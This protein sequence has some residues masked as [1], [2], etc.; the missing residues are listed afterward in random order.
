MVGLS[1]HLPVSWSQRRRHARSSAPGPAIAHHERSQE[2]PR[3]APSRWSR[4][5]GLGRSVAGQVFLLQAA[6]VVALVIAVVVALVLQAR[7]DSTQD[8]RA[9]TLAVA[10]TFANAP[11]T[12]RALTSR[13]PTAILQPRAEALRRQTGV[14][15]VVVFDRNGIRVTHPDP[16]LIGKRVFGPY[17]QQT[18]QGLTVTRTFTTSR[19]PAVD[20]GVPVF[21]A[22][23]KIVG[24]VSVAI[25]VQHVNAVVNR[26]VP[27]VLGAAAVA[28]ALG[29]ASSALVSRRLRR[30]THGLGP[31]EVTRMY[32][33]HDAVLH[34]VREGV[35][36]T[37][38]D[39]RL[40]LANDEARRLLDLPPD[41]ERRPI[42]ALGLDP[43]MVALLT[44]DRP[45]TDQV[46]LAGERLLVVNVRPTAPYGGQAGCA[47]TL[48]DAT[49]LRALAG[50]AERA[51]QRLRLLYEAGMRV[52]TTLDV[53]HTAEEVA[54]VAISL[55]AD[56]ATVEL[57]EP[58][59][60]GAE[61][62]ETAGLL[63]AACRGVGQGPP[64]PAAGECVVWDAATPMAMALAGGHAVLER[65][66]AVSPSW[67]ARVPELAR[68]VPDL[69]LRSLISVPLKARGMVLGLVTFWRSQH[70]DPFEEEDLPVAEELAARAAVCIDNARRYTREHTVAVAMQ[71]SLLPRV[72]PRQNALEVAHRYLPAQAG[73]GGDWFDV[74]PL[75]GA[76]V[77]LVVGDVVGHGLHAAVTMGRLRTAVLNFSALDLP[78]DELLASL[79][80]LVT[81]I[82]QEG[83]E[84]EQDVTG[85]TC[86]Y[87]IYDPVA[88]QV[89]LARAG[90]PGP[91]LVHRDGTVALPDVP[92]S[93][94]LGLGGGLPVESVDL[95]V[96]E[97]SLLVLFTDGLIE[98]RERDI[99]T[100]LALLRQALSEPPHTP[101]RDPEHTCR[102]V[103]DALRPDDPRDDIAL[104]VARTR[105]LDLAR[106]AAWDVPRDPVA[107]GRVR[108][109]AG[110]RLEMWGLEEIAFTTELIISELITNAIRYGSDPI[111]LRLLRDRTLI[112]EVA[113]GSSTSPRLRR[114]A[115]TDE[116]GR[117]LFLVAQL[118]QRWGTRHTHG[119]KVIWTEQALP[120]TPDGTGPLV[121]DAAIVQ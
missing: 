41:V 29:T 16:S 108:A 5:R 86:L 34:A 103:F 91:A 56:Y 113:D 40:M 8:A 84:N 13:N 4:V 57:L 52:G 15:F 107:V 116:G 31:A 99:D 67:L 69:G 111:R 36:I 20:S 7:R 94:P 87:A 95:R 68:P 6:V 33:H 70:S 104:L 106:V 2:S 92:G 42:A 121:A 54:E 100:G 38:A 75:S 74:I 79:D 24:A 50:R 81:R 71:H 76:R 49:E 32:E 97:G 64:L 12:A 1:R 27:V 117:G 83:P 93:P 78:P 17:Q 37:A 82:D 19:G 77:A 72:L 85:A 118:A 65:D 120:G 112:C 11:G 30:Q 60:H 9:R 21:R 62:E 35:L 3:R 46:Q 73:V 44:A 102:A 110:R 45:V 23:G 61:P 22:D 80:E 90:H 89:T 51:Q 28:L 115:T 105:R 10:H 14:D 18:I 58:V 39:G 59:L 47:V 101:A 66:A 26:Q 119:G 43:G 48:R 25:T 109:E 55:F 98:T 63:R 114:A 53:T 96:P 88:E